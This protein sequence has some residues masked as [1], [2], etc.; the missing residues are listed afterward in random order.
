MNGRE[1]F[2][3]IPEYTRQSDKESVC[4]HCLRT[5]STDRYAPLEIAEN[6]HSDVCLQKPMSAPSWGSE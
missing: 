6:I 4:K 3:K 1:S 5:V 2:E